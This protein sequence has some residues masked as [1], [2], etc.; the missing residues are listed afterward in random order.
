MGRRIE[1]I[2]GGRLAISGQG[3]VVLLLAGQLIALSHK[4]LG[5]RQ[6]AAVTLEEE[7][8]LSVTFLDLIDLEDA[9]VLLCD[10]A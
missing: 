1:R 8:P 2:G 3:V 5:G 4:R 9:A 6:G 10:H 7:R